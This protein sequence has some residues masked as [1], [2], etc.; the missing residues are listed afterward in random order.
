MV[1]LIEE[2]KSSGTLEVVSDADSLLSTG[3]RP[4]ALQF[5]FYS[6]NPAVTVAPFDP[7]LLFTGFTGVNTYAENSAGAKLW[8]L[9]NAYDP[10]WLERKVA[11][12][13]FVT[14]T[15]PYPG[16]PSSVHS[17]ATGAMKV[18]IDGFTEAMMNDMYVVE[19]WER[20]DEQNAMTAA[21]DAAL[22]E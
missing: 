11:D 12:P 18:N 2:L 1:E 3:D 17:Q 4:V 21:V 19:T 5:M 7:M 8:A 20:R 10:D 15:P 13:E 16:L 6:E 14:G 22:N 9:W